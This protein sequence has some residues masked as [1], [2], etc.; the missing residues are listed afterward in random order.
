MSSF[1]NFVRVR[2]HC[3]IAT[4]SLS[5]GSQ[6][7]I[8]LQ[9]SSLYPTSSYIAFKHPAVFSFSSNA[10]R[11]GIEG[12]VSGLLVQHTRP[13]Y[14]SGDTIIIMLDHEEDENLPEVIAD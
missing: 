11:R 5:P 13:L 6:H 2:G 14:H 10:A 1:I 7:S 9:P 4:Q 3:I 8:S 12:Q